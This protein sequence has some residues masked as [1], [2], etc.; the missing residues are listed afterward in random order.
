[1][2][3]KP[4]RIPCRLVIRIGL[5]IAAL[6]VFYTPSFSVSAPPKKPAMPY[7]EFKAAVDKVTD[8][9]LDKEERKQVEAVRGSRITNEEFAEIQKAFGYRG[10]LAEC[11]PS[12]LLKIAAINRVLRLFP[13]KYVGALND[14]KARVLTDLGYLEQAEQCYI[15]TT[16]RYSGDLT[17]RTANNP[18]GMIMPWGF[19]VES[20]TGLLA[21]YLRTDQHAKALEECQRLRDLYDP[22]RKDVY[23]S[24]R[25]SIYESSWAPI[26][27]YELH[28]TLPLYEAEALK[29]LGRDD[30]CIAKINGAMAYDREHG[31][32]PAYSEGT[33]GWF[34][35]RLEYEGRLRMGE[36]YRARGEAGK[37][38]EQYEAALKYAE[39]AKDMRPQEVEMVKKLLDG[40][41]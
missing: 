9:E 41:Q 4:L 13:D 40:R 17:T 19:Q 39:T 21:F 12:P 16:A 2:T 26:F 37:E 25:K 7:E 23:A 31:P 32:H 33:R 10:E 1:M 20:M 38:R 35:K 22:G 8:E 18:K 36:C 15:D 28:V 14:T 6:V 24:Y 3:M 30:E 27:R 34:K 11:M 29:G 5:F